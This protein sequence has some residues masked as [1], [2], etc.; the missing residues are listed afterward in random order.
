MIFE[1]L[2]WLGLGWDG[3]TI[4]VLVT[5]AVGSAALGGLLAWGAPVLGLLFV[6]V[7]SVQYVGSM[8]RKDVGHA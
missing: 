1:A 7:A 3:R 6:V 4:L 5:A 8:R 2:R